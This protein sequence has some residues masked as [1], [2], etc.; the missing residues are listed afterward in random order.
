[1]S[2]L[3]LE[4]LHI[5]FLSI[6]YTLCAIFLTKILWKR[7]IGNSLSPT[8]HWTEKARI[9]FTAR[10]NAG[11]LI[12][13]FPVTIVLLLLMSRFPSHEI[14]PTTL[15]LWW[16]CAIS[17]FASMVISQKTFRLYHTA[18]RMSAL[19]S[20][21]ASL[22]LMYPHL[23]VALIFF[24][25]SPFVTKSFLWLWLLSFAIV[26]WLMIT[27][28]RLS[29]AK[30]CKILTPA[31]QLQKMI[32][33]DSS[34][35]TYFFYHKTANA[36]ALLFS[37]AICVSEKL[38]NLLDHKQIQSIMMHEY[39]HFKQN[40]VARGFVCTIPFVLVGG[41][42]IISI[43]NINISTYRI[44]FI[45]VLL[46]IAENIA[47]KIFVREEKE[48]DDFVS[49]ETDNEAYATALE[50][51][52][53][54]N[55]F[56][57]VTAKNTTHPHLYD[58]MLDAGVT[59]NFP[60]PQPPQ[61]NKKM[62][63]FIVVAVLILSAPQITCVFLN[64]NLHATHARI[65]TSGLRTN[66][67]YQLATIHYRNKNYKESAELYAKIS[68]EKSSYGDFSVVLATCSYA[69]A[70]NKEMTRLY[71]EKT[72]KRRETSQVLKYQDEWLNLVEDQVKRL[73]KE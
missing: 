45:L 19:K 63:I 32:P 26:T 10:A 29:I 58:R 22:L 52:Y 57:A 38:Y 23:T 60:R 73:L 43:Y 27:K 67:V 20:I 11:S 36:F 48:I 51:M 14:V 39:Q 17:L 35:T 47:A 24:A 40:N 72:Q 65:L 37:K 9:L 62:F 18:P 44:I 49:K 7:S 30:W 15:K 59:P 21:S 2:L 28:W 54:E 16:L 55:L 12:I 13:I 53:K 70:K 1:M 42:K 66:H 34:I 8:S 41:Y 56:P 4:T 50:I 71:W 33:S 25:I 5:V 31:P 64:Q 68:E 3:W 69:Y 46:I 6:Y 61:K